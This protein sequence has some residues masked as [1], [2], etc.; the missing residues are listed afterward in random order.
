MVC[1]TARP[2]LGTDEVLAIDVLRTTGVLFQP[3]HFY[4]FP[5]EGHL[6]ASL[7]TPSGQ[8]AEGIGRALQYIAD[9]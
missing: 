4:N 7:I 5:G 8:F 9:R 1:G 3:G 2:I 6:I